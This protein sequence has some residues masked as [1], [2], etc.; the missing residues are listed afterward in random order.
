MRTLTAGPGAGY[1]VD[2]TVDPAGV[3]PPWMAGTA[4]LDA[5]SALPRG[6]VV[7]D[8]Y[9]P[10]GAPIYHDFA[11]ASAMELPEILREVRRHPGPVLELAAG[12]GRITMALLGLGRP[13]IALDLSPSMLAIL[14]GRLA[15]LPPRLGTLCRPVQGDMTQFSL[16]AP[17]GV[18]V[19]GTTSISLLSDA[20]RARS[21][22]CIRDALDTGGVL[23]L[24]TVQLADPGDV[25]ERALEAVGDSGRTYRLHEVIAPDRGTRCSVVIDEAEDG[26]P[27]RVVASR[28]ALLPPERLAEDLLAAS[29]EPSLV[30]VVPADRYESVLM[31]A[32]RAS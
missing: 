24:T 21:L 26:A 10:A 8:M 3:L 31:I 13:V 20:Q 28:I 22:R 2:P 6:T 7:Q 15:A 1:T 11:G 18:A 30:R 14:R 12:S 25:A 5:L 23:V 16:E 27:A 19:L 9:S 17:V 29:L 4:T 32:R